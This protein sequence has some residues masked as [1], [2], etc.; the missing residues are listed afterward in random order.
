MGKNKNPERR[1][2][3][4]NE[5]FELKHI[6][7]KTET[8]EKV[9]HSYF[10]G[11]H[12][13]LY[14]VAGTGKTFI[15]LYLSLSDLFRDLTERVIIVRSIVP[16]RDV[17]FLP[18]TIAEKM[19]MYEVPYRDMFAELFGRGDAY[20]ILK[21]KGVVEFISTS[22]LRGV[23]LRNCIVIVDE[24]QNLTFHEADSV[25]TR[26]GENCRFIF[27]GDYRQSDFIKTGDKNG[28]LDFMKIIS[29]MSC[30]DSLE[31]QIRD[32]VRNALIKDYILQKMSL[33]I[34]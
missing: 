5:N 34:S 2:K 28:V 1:K 13:L 11:Q 22:H 32:I 10:S 15:S 12:Q 25:I 23:T 26:A 27:A 4:L 24:I 30:F 29:R 7:P 6:E 14:G 9:F 21:R 20:D 3:I 33:N 19:A 16:T 17:G 8:Q 18:G 31:F